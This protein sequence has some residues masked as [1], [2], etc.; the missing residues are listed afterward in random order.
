MIHKNTSCYPYLDSS[1]NLSP[2]SKSILPVSIIMKEIVLLSYD[3]FHCE[4]IVS[5]QSTGRQG[6]EGK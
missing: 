6:E 1:I 4:E 3:D 2:S 5:Y